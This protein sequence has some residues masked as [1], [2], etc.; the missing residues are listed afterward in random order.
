MKLTP[1]DLFRAG[2]L[3][4]IHAY[5]GANVRLRRTR[6]VACAVLR[7]VTSMQR[8]RLVLAV[9]IVGLTS[10]CIGEIEP[11]ATGDR[12]GEETTTDGQRS[13][14]RGPSVLR[15]DGG[16]ILPG[17]GGDAGLSEPPREGESIDP[18]PASEDPPSSG[19]PPPTP[20][21]P[22]P[23]PQ[24]PPP[25]PAPP[26]PTTIATPGTCSG[27]VELE[28][29]RITNEER[30]GRGLSEL[31][32]DEKLTRAAYLHSQDMCAKNYFSHTGLD[33]STPS[34][35]A[36]AQGASYR[37]IGENIARGQQTPSDVHQ[38]WMNSDG[39][40]RNILSTSYNRIGI[41]YDRCGGRPLWTQVFTN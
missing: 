34:T 23:A 12:D 29:L 28:L 39:H 8:L 10:G 40:R 3:S 32:C 35:R 30:R 2:N 37:T 38:A 21:E 4:R 17:D 25:P 13:P 18:P 24:E 33:G 36:S 11:G 19:E 14:D 27:S 26:P 9:A 31:A 1:G 5:R 7:L 20:Q 15:L 16:A 6:Y 41:G 22:P